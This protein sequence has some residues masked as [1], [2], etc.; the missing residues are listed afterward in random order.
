MGRR[1]RGGRLAAALRRDLDDDALDASREPCDRPGP[2]DRIRSSEKKDRSRGVAYLVAEALVPQVTAALGWRDASPL[3]HSKKSGAAIAGG[4]PR[5]VHAALLDRSDETTS[6]SS[7]ASTS[8]RRTAPA[9]STRRPA[10]GATTTRSSGAPASRW[11]T[12]RS[13]PSTR[14]GYYDANAPESLRG[15]R[16][17]TPKTP[18]DD[19]NRAV[20]EALDGRTTRPASSRPSFAEGAPHSYPH[21]WRCKNPVIFRATHQWFIDLGALR[22]RAMTRDPRPRRVDP[23][24]QREPHR[25]DGRQPPR[26]DDLPPAPLGLADHVPALRRLQGKGRRFSLPGGRGTIGEKEKKAKRRF[27]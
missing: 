8:R 1:S 18:A 7:S 25:R 12:R 3:P 11:T 6:A 2:E 14:A 17:V 26:V 22:D 9:S 13:A 16:V 27:L 10:T 20:L 4:E 23:V 5:C 21:C 24:L 19:A 15:K